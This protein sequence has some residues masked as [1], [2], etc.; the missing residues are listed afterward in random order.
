MT[1][2]KTRAARPRLRTMDEI[3]ARDIEVGQEWFRFVALRPE[4]GRYRVVKV[5]D[6]HVTLRHRT[7][8]GPEQLTVS[9]GALLTDWVLVKEAS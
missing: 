1:K 3:G 6:A 5:A 4:R 2:T 8:G 9:F 7:G